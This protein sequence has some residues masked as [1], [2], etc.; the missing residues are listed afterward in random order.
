MTLPEYVRLLRE[1]WILLVVAVALGLVGAG[2]FTAMS[3]QLYSA[4][5][6]VYILA[7]SNV[8][9][10]DSSAYEAS[11]LAEERMET[12]TAL[13]TSERVARDV[14]ATLGLDSS[15]EELAGRLSASAPPGTVLATV[16]ALDESPDQAAAIA[17]AAAA[18]LVRIVAE[19]EQPLDPARPPALQAR[20]VE[21]AAA[22]TSPVSPQP[23]I[24]FAVGALVGLLVGIGAVVVR[25][26]MDTSIKSPGAL[27][28]VVGAPNLG[29][30]AREKWGH[31]GQLVMME[32]PQSREAE[33]YR[34][35][36]TSLRSVAGH[37]RA[38]VF[39]S[40]LRGEGTSTVVSNL[41]IALGKA[42]YRVVVV[43]ANLREP[44]IA[45][46]L[47]INSSYGLTEVLTGTADAEDALQAWS[48]DQS[49]FYV[50]DSG[51]LR[52]NPGELLGSDRMVRVISELRERN[53]YVLVDA[54]AVLVASDTAAFARF[55]DGVILVCRHG[56]T[57][58]R[59]VHAATE[60]LRVAGATVIGTVMTM[61]SRRFAGGLTSVGR[62]YRTPRVADLGRPVVDVEPGPQAP[63]A[64][65]VARAGALEEA[66]DDRATPA[67]D[68][69][70]VNPR[71]ERYAAA[72]ST[73][74]P[75][76]WPRSGP[77]RTQEAN[78]SAAE[79]PL[80]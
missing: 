21:P 36:R 14:V 63:A 38:V 5:A 37:G 8:P 11:Q 49:G 12:Y 48:T 39:T 7:E 40:A 35:L 31:R 57:R 44:R 59:D 43:D 55:T 67:V 69:S 80:R 20:V 16:E 42:G 50:L 62:P 46:Y 25:R 33:A 6:T 26:L 34:M 15:P 54:P 28:G 53:D 45:K 68:T 9:G 1:R 47:G 74:R 19:T 78:G 41:A 13:L 2:A 3:P 66:E 32:A 4:S 56:E 75:S 22:P 10:D 71:D 23:S 65:P 77:H 70:N 76:P 24:N 30:L 51:L 79:R 61:M 29:S 60:F 58:A 64:P 18:S 17:D 73:M 52:L 72:Y 27:S